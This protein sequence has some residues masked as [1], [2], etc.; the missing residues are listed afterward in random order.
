MKYTFT[1]A[2][3]ILLIVPCENVVITSIDD[4]APYTGG[5]LQTSALEI[6]KDWKINHRQLAGACTIS[7]SIT[8]NDQVS[9]TGSFK[10]GDTKYARLQ[11][12][13][14]NNGEILLGTMKDIAPTSSLKV[15]LTSVKFES[16][17]IVRS[18]QNFLP[19]STFAPSP[20]PTATPT[21]GPTMLS[22]N[23]TVGIV[24]G[25]IFFSIVVFGIA[26]YW[27]NQELQ[28]SRAANF[29]M[30]KRA[31]R[32]TALA[33]SRISSE[34][35]PSLCFSDIYHDSSVGML[36]GSPREHLGI[37]ESKVEHIDP[38]IQVQQNTAS[39]QGNTITSAWVQ[40]FSEK[41]RRDFWRN[42]ITG[43]IVWERPKE[44]S[45][46]REVDMRRFNVMIQ[47][48]RS[49]SRNNDEFALQ[50]GS[51]FKSRHSPIASTGSSFEV[52]RSRCATVSQL[53][54]ASTTTP[55]LPSADTSILSRSRKQKVVR[56]LSPLFSKEK[57]VSGKRSF[58]EQSASE[59]SAILLR[60]NPSNVLSIA[61]SAKQEDIL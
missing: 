25:G 53:A 9:Q 49:T 27:R 39:S 34:E 55:S 22:V 1:N 13:S 4:I 36:I 8:F 47:D 29:E 6:S 37:G 38:T 2:I 14:S 57:S 41:Y 5:Q 40:R 43:S 42:K 28:K 30:V 20:T 54:S 44:V 60:R 61:P 50:I 15:A 23:G 19:K 21:S 17:A 12:V 18:V 35:P 51:S 33:M 26:Y 3:C 46:I 45:F 48:F 11:E 52:S 10:P 24:L 58:N 32:I 56:R 31:G 16:T 7:Y 59:R